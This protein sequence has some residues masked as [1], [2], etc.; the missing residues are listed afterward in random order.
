MTLKAPHT[1]KS[2]NATA[3]RGN[4]S[5]TNGGLGI[6]TATTLS[7]S[8]CLHDSDAAMMMAADAAAAAAG[9]ASTTM[10]TTTMLPTSMTTSISPGMDGL[11]DYQE[12]NSGSYSTTTT[13]SINKNDL[14]LAGGR[15]TLPHQHQ[16]HNQLNGSCLSNGS[17]NSM[18]MPPS[19]HHSMLSSF[20]AAQSAQPRYVYV[21]STISVSLL[22]E[23]VTDMCTP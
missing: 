4:I 13:I 18:S 7:S 21:Q 17:G 20:T 5:K 14:L 3:A 11:P 22:R 1:S 19:M 23:R 2:K 8:H 6:P 16:N 10:T 15:M 12:S 9:S